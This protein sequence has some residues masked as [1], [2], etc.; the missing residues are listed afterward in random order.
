MRCRCGVVSRWLVVAVALA[1]VGCG[2]RPLP[3]P[4][5][6]MVLVPAGEFIMGSNEVDGDGLQEEFGFR[7]PL[8]L[9]EHPRHRRH[10]AAFYID[11]HEVTNDQYKRFVM[12][13]GI[14]E[15]QPWVANAYNVSE[16]R[17]QSFD[18]E[19]LRWV[20]AEYFRLDKD[21]TGMDQAQLLEEL[22]DIQR[23]RDRLPVTGV[24]WYDASSY[25]KWL[26]KRL[27]SEAEWEKA[28]RGAQGRAYPWGDEWDET[29]SNTGELNDSEQILAAAGSFP[30]DVSTFGVYDLGGNVSEW[31]ADWYEPYTDAEYRSPY[32]GGIHKVIKGGGAGIGHY[33]LSYFFR[34]ARRGQADP[35]AVSTDVGFR[36]AG[37]VP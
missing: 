4:P 14:A 25:C 30:Q 9:D 13:T 19:T 11:Q 3:E 17:L 20:V 5:P 23:Q 16:A 7:E 28:A 33:A 29:K 21:T 18:L 35:S 22:G 15:P 1:G 32:Y 36:C 2:E 24:N 27:P 6:G 12:E 31:V 26:G 37:T 8:Y 10:V 34:S